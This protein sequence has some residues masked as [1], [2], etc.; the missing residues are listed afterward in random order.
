[1]EKYLEKYPNDFTDIMALKYSLGFDEV[2]EICNKALS[3]NKRI[4]VETDPNKL[5]YIDYKIK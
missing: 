2:N 1:M 3:E 5:D 4:Y